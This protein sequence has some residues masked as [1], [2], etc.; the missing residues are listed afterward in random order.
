[1]GIDGTID[2]IRN[3]DGEIDVAQNLG[4]GKF[5]PGG[6][7]YKY[8]RKNVDCLAFA[9]E[10][11]GITGNILVQFLTYF[12]LID[13][14]PRVSGGPIPVLIVDCHQ[15]QLNPSFI[16][17]INDERHHWNVCFGVPHATTI[18]QVGDASELNGNF[19]VEWYREKANLMVWKYVKTLP[20]SIL[21]HDIMPLLNTVFH[22]AFG[23]IKGNQKAV[24]DQGWYPPNRKLLEHPSLQVDTQN[25]LFPVWTRYFRFY[26]DI[27]SVI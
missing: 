8:N 20:R 26:L 2:P 24:A 18:W 4:C 10:S 6:P 7:K 22:K 17:Y 19:K 12:D 11:G 15:S 21:P 27:A 3:S 16:H 23:R 25:E 1:M 14:F 5:H 13:L 9:T